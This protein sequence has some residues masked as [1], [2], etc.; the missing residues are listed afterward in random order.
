M[1]HTTKS[2]ETTERRAYDLLTEAYGEGFHVSL[3]VVAKSEEATAETQNAM[4]TIAKELGNLSG[5]KSVTPAIPG[6]RKDLYD[7]R[8]TKNRT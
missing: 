1:T 3:V 7:F 8:H 4:N 2:T 5:V 6:F